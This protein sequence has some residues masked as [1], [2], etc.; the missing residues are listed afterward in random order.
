MQAH[1]PVPMMPIQPAQR[2]RAERVGR[3]VLDL[4]RRLEV[5]RLR[6]GSARHADERLVLQRVLRLHEDV[7]ALHRASLALLLRPTRAKADELACDEW[8]YSRGGQPQDPP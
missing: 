5:L 7:L 8:H 1:I 6:A 3:H 4:L 2:D